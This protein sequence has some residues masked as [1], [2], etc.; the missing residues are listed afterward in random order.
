MVSLAKRLEKKR[1]DLFPEEK[2]KKEKSKKEEVKELP[3]VKPAPI[4]PK[5]EIIRDQDTGKITG[6][7]TPEGKTIFASPKDIQTI[8]AKQMEKYGA[9]AGTIEASQIATARQQTEMGQQA[10][11]EQ[12]NRPGVKLPTQPQNI[13][14]AQALAGG[15]ESAAIPAAVT[16]TATLATGGILAP[17]AV[18]ATAGAFLIGIRNSIK[19]QINQGIIAKGNI[20]TLKTNMNKAVTDLNQGGNSAQDVSFFYQ[21]LD[22]LKINRAQIK[23]DAK[24]VWAIAAGEDATI[25]LEK[26]EN[27]FKYELPILENELNQAILN[28][29]P[30]KILLTAEEMQ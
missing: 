11:Q 21:N 26:Y 17:A 18:T 16:G 9:P 6:I 3:T 22:Q 30:N 2:S 10:I 20:K 5:S 12:Q 23:A 8:A 4:I 14:I 15:I 25:E 24:S 28:P 19:Q 29:N 7:T 27:F 1:K 13:D